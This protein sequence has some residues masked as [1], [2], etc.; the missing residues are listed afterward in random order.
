MSGVK[1][2]DFVSLFIPVYQI[3]NVISSVR[4]PP[5]EVFIHIL[6]DEQ[7]DG[8]PRPQ[9]HDLGHQTLVEGSEPGHVC[10]VFMRKTFILFQ[11]FQN[12]VVKFIMYSSTFL[13]SVAVFRYSNIYI[14][15]L[16]KKYFDLIT[17]ICCKNKTPTI[18]QTENVI[19]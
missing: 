15:K 18:V 4:E 3:N 7:H 2:F 8:A 5:D 17:K 14:Q 6:I 11:L 9:P 12:A 10:Y 16:F 19:K 1:C 13:V